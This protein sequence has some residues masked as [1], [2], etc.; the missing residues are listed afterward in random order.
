MARVRLIL[1]VQGTPLETRE[2]EKSDLQKVLEL[3]ES[4]WEHLDGFFPNAFLL[5]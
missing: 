1:E 4:Y 5:G 3:P 2:V